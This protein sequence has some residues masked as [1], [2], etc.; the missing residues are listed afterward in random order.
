MSASANTRT[1]SLKVEHQKMSEWCWAAV[2]VSVDR[3]FRPAS[4]HTQCDI[5]G[6][7]LKVECCAN[8]TTAPPA[9]CNT[10]EALHPVLGRLHLLAADP[11]VKPLTFAAV[12]KQIDA[13]NPVCV[14]IKWLDKQG[15]VGDRGHFIAIIGY[16]VTPSQKQFVSITD[17]FYGASEIDYT[18]FSSPQGGYRDG[19]GVWFASFLVDNEAANS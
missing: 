5:A 3:F 11:I 13:G 1:V 10:P 16:R 14:L 17:P 8:G 4:T 15:K 19:H 2:S 6:A 9:Q 12:Q 7:T 18:Q